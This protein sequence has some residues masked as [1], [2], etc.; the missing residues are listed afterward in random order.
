MAQKIIR[1]MSLELNSVWQLLRTSVNS[2]YVYEKKQNL[3]SIPIS[4]VNLGNTDSESISYAIFQWSFNSS[5]LSLLGIDSSLTIIKADIVFYY[6][7]SDNP[8]PIKTLD[9]ISC[10][11][12]TASSANTAW[13]NINTAT[14]IYKHQSINGDHKNI[15]SIALGA[16]AND[17]FCQDLTTKITGSTNINIG[18]RRKSSETGNGYI[19]IGGKNLL[20]GTDTDWRN[21]ATTELSVKP[22]LNITYEL[23]ELNHIELDL[24]YTT[25]DPTSDQNTPSNSIGGYMA[26]NRI[27]TRVQI[28]DYVSSSQKSITISDLYSVP[29]LS[30]GIIQIGPEI[31]RYSSVSG[32]LINISDRG[33]IPQSYSFPSSMDPFADFVY[34][35]DI[36]NLF[37]KRPSKNLIQYRCVAIT[38]T[39]T[40]SA[41]NVIITIIQDDLSDVQIDAGIEVP[42]FD[43]RS[44][45]INASVS[46]GSKIFTSASSIVLNYPDNLFAD[47]HII[48][49]PSVTA[50]NAIIKSYSFSAGIATF[51][52]DRNLPALI[53][54]TSFRINPAPSQTITDDIT[55]PSENSN[56]FF[57]FFSNN[58]SN[59]LSFNNIR[60]NQGTLNT[61]DVFYLWV[62]RTLTKNK[63]SSSST[64]SV[65]II[66]FFDTSI[67]D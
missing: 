45:T 16:S 19:E 37:D 47:G 15:A 60:E 63:K 1:N 2:S 12:P 43:A 36:D 50:F 10:N 44:G 65:I 46:S 62:K 51:I 48:F 14:T 27:F 21:A 5:L 20:L 31:M 61:N 33:V 28:G 25:S 22:C 42:T 4:S 53:S 59:I 40:F 11:D 13:T 39:S 3:F 9:F 26:P 67:S 30:S 64:G 23:N 18:I 56:R 6:N 38:N 35:L 57:G 32:Q 49:D 66:R 7:K 29:N 34:Y 54:G 55:S 41:K 17:L 24:R 58:A 52:V 8:Y